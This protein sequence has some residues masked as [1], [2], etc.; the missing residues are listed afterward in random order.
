MGVKTC[1][2]GVKA[3][4]DSSLGVAVNLIINDIFIIRQDCILKNP[5]GAGFFA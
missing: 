4:K 2:F 5:A 3:V 1:F